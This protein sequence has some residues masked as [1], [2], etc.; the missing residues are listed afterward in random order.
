MKIELERLKTK[1]GRKWLAKNAHRAVMIWS[2][3]WCRWWAPDRSGYTS[4]I[5]QAGI[6]TFA[7][8][9]DASGHCGKEKGI[10]YEFCGG[11]S[12]QEARGAA[13]LMLRVI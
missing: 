10:Q 12:T 4:D 3:Q 5:K 7:D 13:Q 1:T 2:N 11:I 9:F 8:A 6:Y